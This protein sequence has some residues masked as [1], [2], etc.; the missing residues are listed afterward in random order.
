MRIVSHKS[1]RENK[2][3]ILC[4]VTF[5][6]FY[7]NRAVYK[8]LW[9]NKIEPD[10][11]QMTIQCGAWALHAGK[12]YRLTLRTCNNYFLS[13]VTV[14]MRTRLNLTFIAYLVKDISPVRLQNT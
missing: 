8:I 11:S 5:F 2:K 1:C 9:K 7:E 10:R 12:L 4:S 14:V 13:T 6:F 3:L